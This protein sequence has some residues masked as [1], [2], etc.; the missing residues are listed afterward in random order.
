MNHGQLHGHLHVSAD[1]ETGQTL[2]LCC[3][4]YSISSIGGHFN[5]AEEHILLYSFFI[6]CSVFLFGN[7]FHNYLF[8]LIFLLQPFLLM[9]SLIN[10]LKK[11][12]FDIYRIVKQSQ[13]NKC[14]K[15]IYSSHET[16]FWFKLKFNVPCEWEQFSFSL[17]L[18]H[19]FL[20]ISLLVLPKVQD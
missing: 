2:S 8:H 1:G 18:S 4:M 3:K 15:D 5:K 17:Y 9:S 7:S 11:T 14:L 6:L 12:L 16:V 19:Y 20:S 10:H 13:L